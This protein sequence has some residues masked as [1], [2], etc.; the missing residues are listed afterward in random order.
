VKNKHALFIFSK[1]LLARTQK[2]REYRVAV[3]K[4][5]WKNKPILFSGDVEVPSLVYVSVSL[6]GAS[7]SLSRGNHE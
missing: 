6:V 4:Y 5:F 2:A 3:L 7:A 1:I